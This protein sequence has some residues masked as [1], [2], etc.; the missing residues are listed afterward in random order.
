MEGERPVDELFIWE[1]D[2]NFW[3]GPQQY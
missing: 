2:F 1:I 3:L